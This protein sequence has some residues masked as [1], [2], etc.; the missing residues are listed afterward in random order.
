MKKA[1]K[2]L[3]SQLHLWLGISSGL[4]VFIVALTGCLLVFEDELEPVIDRQFHIVEAHQG[5]QRLPLDQLQTRV[6][7]TYPGKKLVRITIEKEPE[8]TIVFGLKNGKKEKDILSVAVNP[9]TGNI[10][11]A[12]VEQDAFFSVVLRLHRYLCLEETGKIIT[13]IS[14]V[15]FLI[16]MTTGLIMW[17]PNRK[18]RKQRFTVKWNARFKRLNWDL[19][20]IFGFYVLPFIFLI[21]ITGLVWSY[22]WVNNIIFMTFDGKPQQ[23]RE[24]PAN[25]QPVSN[26]DNTLFQKIY[27]ETNQQLPNPGKILITLGESDSLSVTVSK[28]ND[29]AAISNIVDFLYFDKNN[30]QLI[31][32]RLYA[33]ET[34]GM[35]V[36]RLIYPIHTGSLLGL[37]TKIIAF[38]TALVAATLP[39][40]GIV[41]WLGKKNK[42][43]KEIKPNVSGSIRT[44]RK[45]IIAG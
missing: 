8:R 43:K 2:K 37:P 22:K 13:G 19:H 4:V 14:C 21:A 15:M 11:E 12:R 44:K 27:A 39:V 23:K 36:R 3:A 25:V 31:K 9:Y 5:E 29:N 33:D 24:A 35:K 30:G 38:L 42:S 16:I 40:T 34:K 41:I 6:S 32:K 20:A 7:E 1:L 10:A 17:W 18:N 45:P 28:T 26:Q